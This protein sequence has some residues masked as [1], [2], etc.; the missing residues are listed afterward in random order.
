MNNRRHGPPHKE[1]N[2]ANHYVF[3]NLQT[4]AFILTIGKE[5][6]DSL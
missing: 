2:S 5:E 3:N 4:L 6:K 1:S